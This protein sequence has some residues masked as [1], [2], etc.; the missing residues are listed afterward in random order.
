MADLDPSDDVEQAFGDLIDISAAGESPGQR[1]KIQP[2]LTWKDVVTAVCALAAL[3]SW[4]NVLAEQ[5]LAEWGRTL[6]VLSAVLVVMALNDD[7]GG[8][9]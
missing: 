3:D 4:V 7:A 5:H 1:A 2:S 6:L 9:P 8:N